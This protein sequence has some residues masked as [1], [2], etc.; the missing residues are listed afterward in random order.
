MNNR[1]A[2]A[3][4]FA[5]LIATNVSA[6]AYSRI[7]P[8]S[9]RCE[10]AENPTVIDVH[11]PRLSWINTSKVNGEFQ[12]AFRIRVASDPKLLRKADLWDSGKVESG[13]SVLV[14]YGGE[15]LLSRQECWWQVRVWDSRGRRSRWSRPA[16]WGM[17]LLEKDD[18]KAQWIGAPWQGE[19]GRDQIDGAPYSV[20][21]LLRKSINIS[22]KVV[23]AKAY[24][25]GLGLFE[26]YVNGQKVG[27]Q[28]LCP[29][30]TLYG[31][32]PGLVDCYLPVDDSLF[33]GFRVLYM[34]YDI[35]DLLRQGENVFGAILGCGFY[36]VDSGWALSY[37]SPRFLAQ[38]EIEYAD[39]TSDV[40]VSDGSWQ[41]AESP[42]V[43]DGMYDGETYDARKEI[44]GWCAPDVTL[45]GDWQPAAL[46]RAPDG[47]LHAHYYT[48]DRIM[49]EVAPK[50]I[51]A[52]GDTLEVDFGD[53]LTGWLHFR[54]IDGEAG[55]SLKV[56]YLCESAGNGPNVYIMNGS[57]DEEY[58]ARFTWF[59]FDKVRIVGYPG[60]LLPEN[61]TAEAVYAD[62]ESTGK[63]ACSNELFNR[64]Q[65]IWWRSQTDN[66]HM[67]VPTDCPQREKGPYTG[68]GEIACQTVMHI[69][70][71]GAFY[72]KW[73]DDIMDC[74]NVE[75]GYVT[76]GAPWHPGCG[77]GVGWGAA[78][79]I[80]PWNMYLQY[81][82]R[83]ALEKCWFAMTEQ[84]RHMR[85][86]LREDGTMHQ[87]ISHDGEVVYFFNLGDW[88]P[89]F[90]HPDDALVHTYLL[91]LCTDINARAAD[92]L[93]RTDE[94]AMYRE[95][96]SQVAAD[97]HK[98]FYDPETKSYGDYGSNI[99]ALRIGVPESYKSDVLQSLQEEIARYDGHL[100]TGI[101]ATQLFFEVLADNGL[102][103]LA[104]NAMNKR[105][106][107]SF[108]WWL[109]QGAYTTWEQWDGGN[110]RNH[111]MFGGALT[112]FYRKVAGMNVDENQPGYRHIIFK[113]MPCGDLTW[114]EY[115]NRTPY[116]EAGIRWELVD[117]GEI[118]VEI[119]VPVGCTATLYIPQ[120]DGSYD[121]KE[122]GSGYWKF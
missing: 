8:G 77:G 38:I 34:G 88:L 108:G 83:G 89:P 51:T 47:D 121:M 4:I 13:E 120:P 30:E 17:G 106:F 43:A 52:V 59:C 10:Y 32:R 101:S 37:G 102:N 96:A 60:E 14:P 91:W 53:Y 41:A 27:D 6:S 31:H 15:N 63:F 98:A 62:V 113:P 87:Q 90:E 110:S 104:F 80:V 16:R 23:S 44:G 71:A 112:W 46:R 66:M 78:M 95:Q 119:T 48:S 11:C 50:S 84:V 12:S 21:P 49:E 117:N 85:S 81:G 67:G 20:E 79:N 57:G 99:F 64:I 2:R 76:N 18:W 25:T 86:W 42:I 26:F 118:S 7:R 122:V 22:K 116:G 1:L 3:A 39:G 105:D 35:K 56:E 65:H 68:D 54:H 58:A 97:F 107:P 33:R 70:D 93:G 92:A 115:S 72:S 19:L 40:V 109:E 74:Q 36:D 69:F 45:G 75:T 5:A 9:L 29:N 111:P 82:D 100:N 94:A 61:V 24:V 55:D 73:L 114:A 103:E 28:Q